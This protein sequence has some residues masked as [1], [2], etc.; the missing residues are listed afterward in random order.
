MPPR[1]QGFP[2][3]H[4]DS[5]IALGTDGILWQN[6]EAVAY[7]FP[8]QYR[9]QLDRVVAREFHNLEITQWRNPNI[10]GWIDQWAC[11]LA[12]QHR[13]IDVLVE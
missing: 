8:V 10:V 11:L 4:V 12:E 7:H 3:F 2:L 1:G 5:L 9:D 13:K 6:Y